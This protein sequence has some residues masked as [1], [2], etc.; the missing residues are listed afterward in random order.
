M[1]RRTVIS[2]A[3]IG[4]AAVAIGGKIIVDQFSDAAATGCVWGV[5]VNDNLAIG[6]GSPPYWAYISALESKLGRS[7]A[8]WRR[9][10]VTGADDY[11]AYMQAFDRGWHW[12]YANGKWDA[13]VATNL[14]RDTA[15]GRWDSEYLA[16]FQKIRADERWTST[17]PFHFSFHHEQYVGAE[18]GGTAAGTAPEYIAAFRHVRGLMDSAH[19]SR[20]GNMLMTWVPHWR[21][22]WGDPTF[23]SG[24]ASSAVAPFVVSK[25]DPGAGYY[26][27]IGADIYGTSTPKVSAT[28]QWKPVRD[29]ALSRGKSFF[30]GETGIDGT[31]SEVV[32][33]LEELSTLLRAWGAGTAPGEVEALCWTTKVGQG[34]DYRLDK[35]AAR[36]ARYRAMARDSFFSRTV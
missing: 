35:T 18:F 31:D 1:T 16:Y 32:S 15:A 4:G 12:S 20:S 7:F 27:K 9:N 2:G 14:W 26:D 29:F 25:L 24:Q 17:N 36:L 8:G 3:I 34:G 21:Q 28:D 11:L 10:G 13:G 6:G 5:Q 19:V 33:Y 23:G 22:F 30:T